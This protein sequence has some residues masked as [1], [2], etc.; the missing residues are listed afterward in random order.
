MFNEKKKKKK[1]HQQV[2]K[3]DLTIIKIHHDKES[4]FK[5]VI[6]NKKP[7]KMWDKFRMFDLKDTLKLQ[8]KKMFFFF[9]HQSFISSFVIIVQ[10]FSSFTHMYGKLNRFFILSFSLFNAN[11]SNPGIFFPFYYF[12]LNRCL[13]SS[14]FFC[15]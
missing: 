10:Y 15:D 13:Q 4:N 14:P 8:R 6:L 2:Q 12:R 9:C 5:Y 1:K 11:T 7:C 3:R